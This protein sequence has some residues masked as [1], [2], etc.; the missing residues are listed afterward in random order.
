M[1][2]NARILYTPT[3]HGDTF[4]RIAGQ[5]QA[6]GFSLRAD[7]CWKT[8][9]RGLRTTAEDRWKTPER[10]VRDLTRRLFVFGC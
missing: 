3:T 4:E 5:M 9:G 1:P 6:A 10:E 2:Q 8:S 7:C